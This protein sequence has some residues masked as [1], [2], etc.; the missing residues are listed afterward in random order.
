LQQPIESHRGR[1]ARGQRAVRKTF[2]EQF[3]LSV[4]TRIFRRNLLEIFTFKHV[5]MLLWKVCCC[6][7]CM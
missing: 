2:S 1:S 4:F 5:F 6:L 3:F 7:Y